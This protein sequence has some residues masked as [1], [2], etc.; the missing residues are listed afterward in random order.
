MVFNNI[1]MGVIQPQ[2]M[3]GSEEFSTIYKLPSIINENR[4]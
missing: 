2:L 1:K 3:Q 4:L